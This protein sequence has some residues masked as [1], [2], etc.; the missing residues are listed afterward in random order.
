MSA[1]SENPTRVLTISLP[2]TV[3]RQAEEFARS[4]RVY[5]ST[6]FERTVRDYEKRMADIDRELNSPINPDDP[7]SMTMDQINE[8][9]HEIRRERR[10]PGAA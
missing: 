2:E 10:E 8:L 6:F 9:V 4:Q 7:E 3:A 1:V 5:V